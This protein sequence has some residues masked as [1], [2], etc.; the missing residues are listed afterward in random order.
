MERLSKPHKQNRPLV[1]RQREHP[2]DDGSI[3]SGLETM[4]EYKIISN[5]I[6]TH[7]S[8]DHIRYYSLVSLTGVRG[9]HVHVRHQVIVLSFKSQSLPSEPSELLQGRRR[10]RS[11]GRPSSFS[12]VISHHV[13][14]NDFY[15]CYSKC[16]KIKC[17]CISWNLRK[18]TLRRVVW[19][20]EASTWV[21]QTQPASSSL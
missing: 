8:C 5:H 14:D 1:W 21:S 12:N 11:R 10:G 19:I 6:T 16:D 3:I 7:W 4:F 18:R 13:Q 2:P 9:D 20:H 17:S 15:N